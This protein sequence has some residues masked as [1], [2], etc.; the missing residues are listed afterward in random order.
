MQRRL[1][2]TPPIGARMTSKFSWARYWASRFD[3]FYI[4]GLNGD[5]L[6]DITGNGYDITITGKDFSSDYIPYTSEATFQ[7]PDNA[8]LKVDDTDYLWFDRNGVVRNVEVSELVGYDFARTIIKY[9]NSTPY[10]IRFIGILKSGVTLTAAQVDRLHTYFELPLFWSGVENVNGV[11]KGNRGLTQNVWPVIS[12][13]ALDYTDTYKTAVEADGGEIINF[14]IVQ[15]EY[16]R[17]IDTGDITKCWYSYHFECGVKIN[18]VDYGLGDK[19]MVYKWYNLSP[20]VGRFAESVYAYSIVAGTDARAEYTTDGILFRPTNLDGG[21]RCG[22]ESPGSIALTN[23]NNIVRIR[24]I[25]KGLTG[26]TQFCAK[27]RLSDD[28]EIYLIDNGNRT[29]GIGARRIGV[30]F[31]INS[32]EVVFSDSEDVELSV[33]VNYTTKDVTATKDGGSLSFSFGGLVPIYPGNAIAD[34]VG[35]GRTAGRT[36]FNGYI[37]QIEMFA[38]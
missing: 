23:N 11:I 26:G 24:S 29:L 10:H 22:F 38:L 15:T 17:L 6:K 9:D 37:K 36:V 33:A 14:K 2:H 3:F 7:I 21:T 31:I 34:C 30:S 18:V 1:R 16:Q 12:A 32:S 20:V 27:G 25:V 4:G 5:T 13:A 35:H 28:G 19:N 8:T